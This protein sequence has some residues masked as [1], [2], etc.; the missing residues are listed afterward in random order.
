MCVNISS[1]YATLCDFKMSFLA[2]FYIQKALFV[3]LIV[4][5]KT[6]LFLSAFISQGISQIRQPVRE[7]SL[8]TSMN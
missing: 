1:Y 8:K 3:F 7:S 2:T 5:E 4:K 6:D